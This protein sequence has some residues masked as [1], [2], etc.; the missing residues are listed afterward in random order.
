MQLDGKGERAH[1]NKF[2]NQLSYKFRRPLENVTIEVV[3]SNT[4]NLSV[5]VVVINKLIVPANKKE[6]LHSVR[7]TIGGAQP[8]HLLQIFCCGKPFQA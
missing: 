8:S 2:I 7:Y 4:N 3:E 5:K 1:G 6:E